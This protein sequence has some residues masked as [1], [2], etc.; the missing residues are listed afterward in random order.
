MSLITLIAL[1][2]SFPLLLS[3]I[4]FI[5]LNYLIKKYIS[6]TNPTKEIVKTQCSEC[7]ENFDLNDTVVIREEFFIKDLE[8]PELRFIHVR[9]CYRCVTE[10]KLRSLPIGITMSLFLWLFNPYFQRR[11]FGWYLSSKPGT[12]KLE[13]EQ[14]L[15]YDKIQPLEVMQTP[16]TGLK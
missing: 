8:S 7:K 5:S 4:C 3:L 2:I 6:G 12:Q 13:H 14:K 9:V 1:L 10:L 15:K 16:D 11:I